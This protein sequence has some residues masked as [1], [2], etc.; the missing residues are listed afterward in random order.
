MSRR[1]AYYAY[2]PLVT[3][4]GGIE[5]LLPDDWQITW[6]GTPTRVAPYRRCCQDPRN[7]RGEGPTRD[8]V[9]AP[10]YRAAGFVAVRNVVCGVCGTQV[11]GHEWCRT[12]DAGG[13]GRVVAVTDTDEPTPLQLAWPVGA[14]VTW[15]HQLRGG[16]QWER[17]VPA[18]VLATNSY[19]GT[20]KI[21]AQLRAGGVKER[22]VRPERLRREDAQ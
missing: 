15:F 1:D 6:Q 20:V 21:A 11:N 8:F 4:D 10:E 19:A 5:G 9:G 2:L 18:T 13:D 3:P 22:W 14:S 7:W 16:Y 17:P 12:A